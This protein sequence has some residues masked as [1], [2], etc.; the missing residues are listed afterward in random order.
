MVGPRAGAGPVAGGEGLGGLQA[1]RARVLHLFPGPRS[2]RPGRDCGEPQPDALAYSADA[3]VAR[4]LSGRVFAVRSQQKV[5][6]GFF[7]SLHPRDFLGWD[8]LAGTRPMGA[9]QGPQ[10]VLILKGTGSD[11]WLNITLRWRFI[12]LGDLKAGKFVFPSSSIV[13]QHFISCFLC[14]PP[15]GRF[16]ERQLPDLCSDCL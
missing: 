10:P 2:G 8:G 4:H 15:W 11:G 9:A 5:L 7:L 14:A 16:R 13:H 12:H 6:F 1:E 3:L